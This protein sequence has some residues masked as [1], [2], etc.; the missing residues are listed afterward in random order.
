MKAYVLHFRGELYV[1][2]GDDCCHAS[3]GMLASLGIPVTS[4]DEGAMLEIGVS[5]PSPTPDISPETSI[6]IHD[7]WMYFTDDPGLR[8]RIL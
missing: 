1:A 2:F 6:R 8:R 3:R 4:D 5:S 7:Y